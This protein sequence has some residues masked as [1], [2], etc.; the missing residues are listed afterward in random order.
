ML[1]Q[2]WKN[3]LFWFLLLLT[4]F[5]SPQ[6]NRIS[7]TMDSTIE[8]K[9]LIDKI[10]DNP[11]IA[12]LKRLQST[13]SVSVKTRELR[14]LQQYVLVNLLQTLDRNRFQEINVHIVRTI[15]CLQE[16]S[17]QHKIEML[18]P[19]KVI[20]TALINQI[21]DASTSLIRTNLSE[22]LKLAVVECVTATMANLETDLICE[23]YAKANEMIL[24][25]MV[26]ASLHLIKHETYR[27]L[28]FDKKKTKYF[29]CQ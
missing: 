1:K 5:G 16:C 11:C 10:V 7:H 9:S 28:R 15:T 25:R 18:M 20:T 26:F 3:C 6:F 29:L 4:C 22:E 23:F 14:F 27:K 2:R 24:A 12:D 13:I 21:M 8:I 17:K 19:V